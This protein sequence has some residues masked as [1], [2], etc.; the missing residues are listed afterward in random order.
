MKTSKKTGTARS[1]TKGGSSTNGFGDQSYWNRPAKSRART[2]LATKYPNGLLKF[3]VKEESKAQANKTSSRSPST[4]GTATK[5]RSPLHRPSYTA[6]HNRLPSRT[7]NKSRSPSPTPSHLS[8]THTAL[9][10]TSSAFKSKENE[11]DDKDEKSILKIMKCK[12]PQFSN[13]ADW[14]L[15][16]FELGLVL[17][18][19]WPHKDQLDI[20]EYMTTAYHRSSISSSG[21]MEARADRLIYFALTMAAKKDSFAKLQIMAACAPLRSCSLC[22]EKRRKEIVLHVS[23]YVQHD[24]PASSQPAHRQD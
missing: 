21:V 16:I 6:I 10:Q 4:T 7:A 13:E 19:V 23:S 18:R 15:A 2:M 11:D 12:L 1:T 22:P 5:S 14:E 9:S 24:E 8:S 3:K 17:D 20:V